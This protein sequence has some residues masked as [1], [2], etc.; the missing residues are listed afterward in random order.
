MPPEIERQLLVQSIDERRAV[1]VEEREK[2]D[3][4]LLRMAAGEGERSRMDELTPQGFVAAL[5]R[6]NHLAVQV[7]Q[8]PLHPLERRS[9]GP[10]ERRIERGHRLDDARH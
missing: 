4:A 1:R 2:P 7:L 10:F 8:V 6:L 3:R 5:G 9:G